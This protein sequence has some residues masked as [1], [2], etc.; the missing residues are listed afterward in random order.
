MDRRERKTHTERDSLL[1]KI[2]EQRSGKIQ[3]KRNI[4]SVLAATRRR[5]QGHPRL[6]F[7]IGISM[8]MNTLNSPREFGIREERQS[9]S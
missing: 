7:L 2:L 9:V 6:C 5:A 8:E 1:I 4:R 3:D